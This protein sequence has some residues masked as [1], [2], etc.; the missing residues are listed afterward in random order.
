VSSLDPEVFGELL[1]VRRLAESQMAETL[2]AV[3]LGDR[4]GRSYVVKRPRL[5]ER[6]SGPA[7]QAIVREADV[8]E[9]V[10][11]PHLVAFESRGTLAGLPYLVVEH[12]RGAALDRILQHAG[13]LG[14]PETRAI[15]RD[16]LCGLAALHEAG[17]VHGDVAPSNIVVDETGESRLIDLGIA[18]RVGEVR[19]MPAGKPGYIAPEAVGSRPAAPAEDVYAVGVVAAECLTGRRLFPE[20]DLSEAATRSAVSSD[21]GDRTEWGTTLLEALSL[22]A[23]KRPGANAFRALLAPCPEGRDALADLVARARTMPDRPSRIAPLSRDATERAPGPTQ[24]GAAALLGATTPPPVRELTPTVPLVVAAAS[25][26]L[27]SESGGRPVSPPRVRRSPLP[28]ILVAI[29]AAA[30]GW[31]GGRRVGNVRGAREASIGIS[32]PLPARG[33]MEI[34]GR[35]I[36]P[37]EPG[38]KIPVEPGRH[39]I[40]ISS[41]RKD[42]TQTFDIVVGAG[43]HVV[44]LVPP[45]VARKDRR[46]DEPTGNGPE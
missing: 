17:W 24:G 34:D 3:R 42:T 37:P 45:S 9:A 29:V 21:L 32:A 16:V 27:A 33:R 22:D 28:F 25:P 38:K 18:R 7:A 20:H 30:A 36:A 41:P 23:A 2:V 10:R 14:E 11:S 26:T 43:E 44:L 6:A 8:L 40:T 46:A 4:S 19:P 39:A 15:V 13:P 5:G 12:L 35:P 31:F 1:L